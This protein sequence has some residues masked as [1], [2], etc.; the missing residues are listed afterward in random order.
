MSIYIESNLK[1]TGI[2]LVKTKGVV[3]KVEIRTISEKC[4]EMCIDGKVSWIEKD[5]FKNKYMII[6]MLLVRPN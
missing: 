4:Y 1:E 3:E 6:E 2:Y 5:G